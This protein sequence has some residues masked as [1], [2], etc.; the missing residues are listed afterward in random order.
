MTAGT[1]GA[2]IPYIQSMAGGRIGQLMTGIKNNRG[3]ILGGG[4]AAIGAGM[5][6]DNPSMS[7]IGMA[8]MTAATLSSEKLA[9]LVRTG[10]SG[11]FE[12]SLDALNT[13]VQDWGKGKHGRAA[14]LERE[15]DD[16]AGRYRATASQDQF[17]TIA[18]A[19]RDDDSMSKE[20]LK[21][22][23]QA[24]RRVG[25][26]GR[27]PTE[28]AELMADFATDVRTNGRVRSDAMRRIDAVLEGVPESEGR[29]RLARMARQG[30]GY[31]RSFASGVA[32]QVRNI[33]AL[34]GAIGAPTLIAG[35]TIG[36]LGAAA[37]MNKRGDEV[38]EKRRSTN[39]ELGT[40]VAAA[41]GMVAPTFEGIASSG[42]KLTG[43]FDK[44]SE[45]FAKGLQDSGGMT[46]RLSYS[47]FAAVETRDKP[48]VDLQF[49][50]R[51]FLWQTTG[52]QMT[53]KQAVSELI[54]AYGAVLT[55]Q[56]LAAMTTDLKAQGKTYDEVTKA[57]GAY[58]EAV[59]GEGGALR[60]VVEDYARN[61]PNRMPWEAETWSE[62]LK[63]WSSD[64]QGSDQQ[65]QLQLIEELK[66]AAPGLTTEQMDNIWK[67]FAEALGL[68][69]DAGPGLKGGAALTGPGY[70]GPGGTGPQPG[71]QEEPKGETV[72]EYNRRKSDE[73]QMKTIGRLYGDFEEKYRAMF[74]GNPTGPLGAALNRIAL[75]TSAEQTG[76]PL[77][78]GSPEWQ[79]AQ[80]ANRGN[81]QNLIAAIEGLSQAT[82][83]WGEENI[84]GNLQESMKNV[85]Q[86]LTAGGGISG[87]QAYNRQL[88]MEPT[89]VGTKGSLQLQAGML[90]LGSA[91]EIAGMDP[92]AQIKSKQTDAAVRL[93]EAQREL[94]AGNTSAEVNNQYK[95]AMDD[96]FSLR[97]DEVSFL[98]G[99]VKAGRQ[100][101]TSLRYSEEDWQTSRRYAKEDYSTQRAQAAEQFATQQRYA[102]EAYQRQSMYMEEDYQQQMLRSDREYYKQRLYQAD[103]YAKGMRRRMEDAAKG[104]MDPFQRIAVESTWSGEGLVANLAEQEQQIREQIANLD[105]LRNQG[106][107]Q[108]AID[109]LGLNDPGKAQQLNRLLGDIAAGGNDIVSSLN[110][111]AQARGELAGGLFSAEND[112]GTRRMEEDYNTAMNRMAEARKTFLSDSAA[113]YDKARRRSQEAFETSQRQ[114]RE[115]FDTSMRYMEQAHQRSLTRMD[116]AHAT[117]VRRAR[118]Q[119]EEQFIGITSDYETLAKTATAML[120]GETVE[121]GG[122]ITRGTDTMREAFKTNAGELGS[123]WAESFTKSLEDQFGADSAVIDAVKNALL[124]VGSLVGGGGPRP[125][126]SV[127]E[128]LTGT[129]N[130]SAGGPT[131]VVGGK[132][133]FNTS[134]YYGRPSGNYKAGHHTGADVAAEVGTPI[135]STI[136]GKV[137]KAGWDGAYG[138]AVYVEGLNGITVLYAHMSSVGTV[139]GAT[140]ARGTPIG[141]VG[142]TGNSNGPHVH[143]E[144]RSATMAGYPGYGSDVNP[145]PYMWAGGIVNR[146]TTAVIGEGGYGE[147][148]IP[149]NH[150]GIDVLS[151]AL[152]RAY[153]SR[154]LQQAALG[155]R[156]PQNV[157]YVVTEDH[158]V[159]VNGSVEVV[160]SDPERIGREL[161]RMARSRALL[162]PSRRNR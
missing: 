161:E 13:P 58:T 128:D 43:T 88:L 7:M 143:V 80:T 66:R 157:T 123:L 105:E 119:F 92:Y 14:R 10:M 39:L 125:G 64:F 153:G 22:F 122:I 61:Q 108:S 1:L 120:N 114:A 20:E 100:L 97:A 106:V 155:E 137:V 141:R 32:L 139:A 98:Q 156:G 17:A 59:T 35:G 146:A 154:A 47:Q 45:A 72:E 31:G 16:V 33:P 99:V 12:D 87:A 124:L 37:W 127:F 138:N 40:G 136:S 121:W 142:S 144:A 94:N 48:S 28:V 151:Q 50:N 132:G 81:D 118:E 78:P 24:A 5:M 25:A 46:G 160:S 91:V 65:K 55:P 158:S 113:D 8:A 23:K 75:E 70:Q 42:Q 27:I 76:V 79:R 26:G 133:W 53:S 41:Y 69:P 110:S 21:K 101:Q 74:S 104:M 149:L 11:W 117:S 29:D 109:I 129:P 6:M 135:F 126:D 85:S 83:K 71:K 96:L 111:A 130:G 68:N 67:D 3:M 89:N 112:M 63:R 95:Q 34:L 73:W 49:Q 131:W 60:A 150:R 15:W 77:F 148:V 152:A 162:S 44:L 90:A 9:G 103:D 2:A 107:S 4:A 145:L 19:I 84:A 56:G 147:A 140:V 30:G 36:A 86:W 51:R 38:E 82:E 93:G 54:A 62:A 52:S 18:K 102:Q 57:I 159:N 134:N 116:E 115:S